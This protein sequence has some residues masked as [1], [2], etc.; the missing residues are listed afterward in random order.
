MNLKK[1]VAL[2]FITVSLAGC[3]ATPQNSNQSK[4]IIPA[5]KLAEDARQCGWYSFIAGLPYITDY[6]LTL[7]DYRVF[8]KKCMT[9]R[10]YTLANE[11]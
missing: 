7:D 6:E 9:G 2:G 3:T 8:Y 10:G 4:F 5:E 1:L 11:E